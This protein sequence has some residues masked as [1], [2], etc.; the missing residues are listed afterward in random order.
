MYT[1]STYNKHQHWDPI[2]AAVSVFNTYVVYDDQLYLNN[3]H[4]CTLCTGDDQDIAVVRHERTNYVHTCYCSHAAIQHITCYMCTLLRIKV[5]CYKHIT[6]LK[7]Q[8]SLLE[9]CAPVQLV[10]FI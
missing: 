5:A 1:L 9:T 8:I 4:A 10:S 6:H 3:L 2:L 7:Y